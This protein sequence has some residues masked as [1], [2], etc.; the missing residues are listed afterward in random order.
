MRQHN[1]KFLTSHGGPSKVKIGRRFRRP[2]PGTGP[3]LPG[4]QGQDGTMTSGTAIVSS[5]PKPDRQAP[6]VQLMVR[7]NFIK[8][9]KGRAGVAEQRYQNECYSH[10][11]IEKTLNDLVMKIFAISSAFS[12]SLLRKSVNHFVT[13]RAHVEVLFTPDDL[14]RFIRSLRNLRLSQRP[15]V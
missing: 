12:F 14:P 4:P 1:A 15:E 10:K 2:G 7:V 5:Q 6:N 9:T 3:L 11:L 13:H 8:L